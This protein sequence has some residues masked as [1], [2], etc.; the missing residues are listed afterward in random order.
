MTLVNSPRSGLP[1]GLRKALSLSLILT[2]VIVPLL[3]GRT[4]TPSA[5]A[6]IIICGGTN[7]NRIFQGCPLGDPNYEITLE[8]AALDEL[9][10]L[11]QLPPADRGRLM[12][13]ERGEMRAHI[14]GQLLDVIK[15]A[16]SARADAEKAAMNTLAARVKSKRV[17]AA[18]FAVDEYNRWKLNPCTY[19]P[20]TG[21]SYSGIAQCAGA[22]LNPYATVDPPKFEEFQAYGVARSFSVFQDLS[23]QR[24]MDQVVHGVSFLGGVAAGGIAGAALASVVPQAVIKAIFPY[25]VRTVALGASAGASG[26][27]GA[28]AAVGGAVL[29]V[30]AAIV[31]GVLR[32]ID[33]FNNEAIPGKLQEKLDEARNAPLPDL[34]QL[35]ANE[36]GQREIFA[37]FMLMTLPDFPATDAV[38]APQSSDPQFRV[39]QD[40]AS[41]DT[42]AATINF[43]SWDND[44]QSARASGGWFINKY[45]ED[46]LDKERWTLKIEYVNWRSEKWTAARAGAGF[47]HSKIDDSRQTFQSA[48]IK[49]LDGSGNKFTASLI[50][51]KLEITALPIAVVRNNDPIQT[52]SFPNDNTYSIARVNTDDGQPLNTLGIS[53]NNGASA[54][55]TGV[56]VSNLHIDAAGVVTADL[57]AK[58]DAA[59]P[60]TFTLKVTSNGQSRTVPLVV[61][62]SPIAYAFD[63]TGNVLSGT[64]PEGVVGADYKGFLSPSGFIQFCTVDATPTFTVTGGQLP[65]ELSFGLTQNCTIK[66]GFRVCDFGNHGLIG[67]PT[68]GGTYDFT[69]RITF[70][71]GDSFTRD[72]TVKI[73]STPVALPDGAVSWWSGEHGVLDD[74]KRNQ[75]RLNNGFNSANFAP[76]KVGLAFSFNGSF[77]SVQLPDNFFPFAPGGNQPFT[78]ETWFKTGSGGVILGRQDTEPWG[79]LPTNYA[80]GIYVGND[81]RLRVQMFWNG[82]VLGP[83][84]PVTSQ[85]AVNDNDFHH[86]AV[87]YD[88]TQQIVYLDGAE[89]GRAT[90]AP[91]GANVNYKYQLGTGY[92]LGWPSALSGSPWFGFNGLID[93][94]TM[95]SRAIT[96]EEVQSIYA[97]GGAG[98]ISIAATNYN[99]TCPG[100]SNGFVK[101]GV[102]GG[103]PPFTYSFDGGATFLQHNVPVLGLSAGEVSIAVKDAFG[104]TFS[105]SA[106]L[107]DPQPISL[108][109]ASLTPLVNPG[110]PFTQSFQASG[111]TGNKTLT[112]EGALPSGLIFTNDP[113]NSAATIAG[114][115][116]Q[117]GS[118]PVTI[119]STDEGGCPVSQSYTLVINAPPMMTGA[120]PLTRQQGATG[121]TSTVATVGDDLTPASHLT[122][123]TTNVPAGIT[124]TN[125]VNAD[126]KITA[127]VAAACTA[128]LGAHAVG[129]R[130]TDGGG[131]T[132]IASL[133]VNVTVS[134]PPAINVKPTISLWPPNR[135]YHTLTVG[136][137]V[138]SATDDCDGNL[139]GSVVVERVTSDE[140]DN[141]PG[142]TDGNT[143]ND[144]VIGADCKSVQLRAERDE[145]KN[146]RVYTITLRVRDSSGNTTRADYK[147]SVP[148]GQNGPA[149]QEVTAQTKTS[150]CP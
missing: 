36:N 114:T 33:V 57:T 109:P 110:Q 140:A 119:T 120:S 29:I 141:A 131:L 139:L 2:L 81:G 148:I 68:T 123:T 42:V 69:V 121:T 16:P 13:W 122:V 55:V 144:I 135:N 78:F 24:Q 142:D 45:R 83:K 136:Q 25:A 100:A 79:L 72:Y 87:I 40:G 89:M 8:N 7:S 117:S 118:F 35:N 53:V 134:S 64:L 107:T 65:P 97:A 93:E 21:F 30:V 46:N 108:S 124:V 115:A 11:H 105:S 1:S 15:K 132:A 63:E 49:Y 85:A 10:D 4:L 73:D 113:A 88:G 98:K 127:D 31:I 58:C 71:N 34:A 60:T 125:I 111:G 96:P 61:R 14:Y 9:L 92:A 147:V 23:V 145:G 77:G 44:N 82:T 27:A 91:T 43:Q 86:V 150:S 74:L 54:T 32:G 94:P 50:L 101:V 3:G 41:A 70:G 62:L 146:G 130:V 116:T 48:E 20:P 5:Q 128:A 80:P 149:V 75:G 133:T 102:I 56:T 12:G 126:G 39:R 138:A 95:Y 90:Y 66:D 103:A 76:G 106:T 112:L 38:P 17:E 137:M 59:N 18:Q 26:V 104:R 19:E 129:L 47:I 52:S 22:R 37:A 51:P 28:T 67:T 84:N 143:I 99:P 6:Q